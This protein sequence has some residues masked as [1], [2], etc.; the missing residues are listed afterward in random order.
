MGSKKTEIIDIRVDELALSLV[1]W[2]AVD[3]Q[4]RLLTESHDRTDHEQQL[5]VSATFRFLPE[6]W[7]ERF[8]DSDGDD[9][10]SEVFL[11]LNRRDIPAPTSNHKWVVL[12]KIRKATK[13]LIRVSTKSDTWTR[14]APLTAKDLDLRLTAYDLD[15]VSDLYI[16]SKLSLPGP[17]TTPL[18]IIVVDET[19]AD[20]PR[21]KVAIAHA[22]LSKGDYRTTLTVHAEGT[23]EFGS[24][25]CLL[26]AYVDR[27]DWADGE[28]TVKDSAPF[29]V[30]VPE[31]KFEILDD[32]G[33]LLDNRTCRFHG[34]IPI[35]DQGSVPRR[36]PRWIGRDVIDISKLPGDPHRVVVRVTDGE[37]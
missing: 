11:T 24:A 9:F 32:S 15:Y 13:G 36:Q 6:D 3:A 7:T 18:E 27:H 22:Y 34:H 25:E 33:F 37:E 29:E 12:E 10:A 1:G 14:R 31:V 17:T 30:D 16:N 23:F 28:S 19:S 20:A 2:Q 8:K 35:D 4:A 5:A 21:A 26:K